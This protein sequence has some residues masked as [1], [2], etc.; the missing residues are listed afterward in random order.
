MSS[1][2]L[3]AAAAPTRLDPIRLFLDADIVVQL[4]M[5]GL[6]LASIWVWMIIV[7]FSLRVAKLRTT[8]PR[9]HVAFEEDA[10]GRTH[11][12]ALPELDA[13]LHAA[14]VRAW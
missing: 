14:D 8:F 11:K 3:L 6:L 5:T 7:S 1:L 2:T 12:H 13:Y 9:I 4:V 10:Q